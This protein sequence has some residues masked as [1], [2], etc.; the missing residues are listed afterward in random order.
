IPRPPDPRS[1]RAR[2]SPAARA[3]APAGEA[4]ATAPAPAA[5]APASARRGEDV[6][7]QI[8]DERGMRDHQPEE[9][10]AD[11]TEQ[12]LLAEAERTQ[13]P[14]LVARGRG[15]RSLAVDRGEQGI[16]ACRDRAVLVAGLQ[17]GRDRLA[18]DPRGH[19]VG[20][21]VLEAVADLDPHLA[22]VGQDEE[23]GAV[24]AGPVSDAPGPERALREVFN[25]RLAR[26]AADPDE[27]LRARGASV[28]LEPR[29]ERLAR[30][31]REEAGAVRD[32]LGGGGR[33]GR[34][35]GSRPRRPRGRQDDERGG[36]RLADGEA[37]AWDD[38]EQDFDQNLTCGA[39][40]APSAALK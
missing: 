38:V 36:E 35:V 28:G 11:Q 5:A 24:V 2:G 10:E 27:D 26:R 30:G 8:V 29:R 31:R 39:F 33:D 12:D 1:P 32:V 9:E 25:R 18:D 40:S 17:P 4:S 6:H 16:D 3:A 13:G 22:V 19:E 34:F 15:R 14:T 21:A 20:D 37:A 23:D 7:E